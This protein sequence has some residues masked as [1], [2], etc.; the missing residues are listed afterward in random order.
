MTV[1]YR[2]VTV[3][4]DHC[5]LTSNDCKNNVG[6][7]L[8]GHTYFN[9]SVWLRDSEGPSLGSGSGGGMDD[10][11]SLAVRGSTTRDFL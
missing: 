11:E 9:L 1:G 8:M 4:A 2:V 7:I 10:T 3:T 5:T 6:Q